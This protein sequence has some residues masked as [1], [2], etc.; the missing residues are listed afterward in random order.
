MTATL[1]KP[2]REKLGNPADHLAAATIE[3][4]GGQSVVLLSGEGM[5]SSIRVRRIGNRFEIGLENDEDETDAVTAAFLN[6][7]LE[8]FKKGELE[9]SEPMTADAW[10]RE[11]RPIVEGAKGALRRLREEGKGSSRER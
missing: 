2:L 1:K 5:E 3:F 10:T 6:L 11:R 4:D 9:M 8:Q 7:K